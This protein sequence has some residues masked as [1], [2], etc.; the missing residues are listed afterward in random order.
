MCFRDHLAFL[1][2]SNI[3]ALMYLLQRLQGIRVYFG[4]EVGF[5]DGVEILTDG[6]NV[7]QAVVCDLNALEVREE[8]AREEEK[9][10]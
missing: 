4:D 7:H 5:C 6:E 10:D 2:F 1:K 3:L 9:N 8:P